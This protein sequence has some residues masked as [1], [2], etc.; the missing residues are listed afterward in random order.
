M[1]WPAPAS[2]LTIRAAR[3]LAVQGPGVGTGLAVATGAGLGV[4]AA[5]GL[6]LGL[7]V[8][9]T[10]GIGDDPALTAQPPRSKAMVAVAASSRL[11][12]RS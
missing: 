12:A 11:I 6:G 8:T 7:G 10:V 2:Q 9:A 1:R 3:L 5:V 4:I